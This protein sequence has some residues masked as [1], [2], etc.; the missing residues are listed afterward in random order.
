MN[1][2]MNDTLHRLKVMKELK[3]NSQENN[4]QLLSQ[5]SPQARSIIERVEKKHAKSLKY[6]ESR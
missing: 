2:M 5:L 6:L 3:A 4:E 1:D